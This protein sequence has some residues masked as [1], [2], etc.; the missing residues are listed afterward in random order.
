MFKKVNTLGTR[1]GK[2]AKIDL[3]HE[4]KESLVFFIFN[5]NSKI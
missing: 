2:C 1:K 4:F 5:T 3:E